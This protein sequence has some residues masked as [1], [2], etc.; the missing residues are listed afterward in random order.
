MASKITLILLF[1]ILASSSLGA[2]IFMLR[3]AD[4]TS[5]SD[6]G[7]SKLLL[8]FGIA[9]TVIAAAVIAIGARR[10]WAVDAL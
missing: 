2:S 6:P 4:T 10:V 7:T 5:S 3:R 1:G 9:G 8:G